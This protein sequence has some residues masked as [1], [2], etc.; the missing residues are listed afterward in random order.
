MNK[1]I[2]YNHEALTSAAMW[3]VDNAS[4]HYTTIEVYDLLIN[5]MRELVREGDD[6][7]ESF[8]VLLVADRDTGD[9]DIYI[10]IY[11][12]CG[13]GTAYEYMSIPVVPE[14]PVV[15]LEVSDPDLIV[16]MI[17]DEGDY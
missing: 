11:T 1:Q 7:W 6:T 9:T 2:R 3:I 4:P 10:D 15:T 16:G 5:S 8:G 12:N 14:V 13:A 17:A